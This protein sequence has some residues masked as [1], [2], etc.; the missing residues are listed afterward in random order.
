MVVM[1]YKRRNSDEICERKGFQF[2]T[3]GVSQFESFLKPAIQSR[4]NEG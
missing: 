4:N 2:Q 3:A 1:N